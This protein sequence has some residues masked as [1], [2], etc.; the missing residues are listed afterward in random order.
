MNSKESLDL[1]KL[2]TEFKDDYQDN[3]DYIR[4][5]KHSDAIRDDIHRLVALKSEKSHL[6]KTSP[7][8]FIE[9]A[10]TEIFFLFKN[11][12]DIFN[13][14]I[15]DEI[16]MD[17]LEQVLI[18]LKNIENG[19]VDQNEGSVRVG[20]LLKELYVDSALKLGAK[21]DAENPKE[22]KAEGRNIDW[23]SWKKSGCI[24][25]VNDIIEKIQPGKK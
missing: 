15:K 5:V 20:I 23:K 4:K 21:I 1:K 16:D 8:K 24:E 19:E 10:Q 11:Y 14:I 6:L 7:N 17:I 22:E 18:V 25:R 9:L 13:K 12:T 3:T 2:I